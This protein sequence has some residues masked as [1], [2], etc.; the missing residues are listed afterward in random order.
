[1][2]G[3]TSYGKSYYKFK[4]RPRTNRNFGGGPLSCFP[5]QQVS[6]HLNGETEL[7]TCFGISDR[8][9]AAVKLYDVFRNGKAQAGASAGA[10]FVRS[11]EC[12]PNF[13]ECFR[14]QGCA[15]VLDGKC[16]TTWSGL[17]AN[18]DVA[19]CGGVLDGI[20]RKIFDDLCDA[21]LVCCNGKRF[22]EGEFDV[23]ILG[24]RRHFQ[25]FE[26]RLSQVHEGNFIP[27]QLDFTSFQTG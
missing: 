15:V 26:D 27:C 23:Q 7:N 8:A 22:R 24:L 5:E 11:V 1:M 2:N 25:F 4:K 14:G 20:G 21:A 10:G 13:A 18:L 17:D 6:T 3:K 19:A 9:V 12:V 16:R